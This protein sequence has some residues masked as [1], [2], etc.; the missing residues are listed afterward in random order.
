MRTATGYR[1]VDETAPLERWTFARRD[2]RVD[3]VA[4]RVTYCGVCHTDLHS[5]RNPGD[6]PVVPGHEF[7]GE[8]TEIG[9]GV[10]DFAVG[11]AVAVGN[12]VDSCGRCDMCTV[13]QENFCREFPTLT[14][15]GRDRHDELPLAVRI[16]TSTWFAIGSST[17]ARTTSTQRQ[18]HP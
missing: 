17:T 14:Y 6:F 11:D 16:P 10:T 2:L 13:G 5:T 9:S 15:G 3:D 4:V 12:I 18:W 8:V 7:V 1:A